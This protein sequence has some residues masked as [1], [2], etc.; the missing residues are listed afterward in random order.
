MSRI[1]FLCSFILSFSLIKA[2][3]SYDSWLFWIVVVCYSTACI[4]ALKKGLKI[5]AKSRTKKEQ[6]KNRRAE[7][8]MIKKIK[9][10]NLNPCDY[11]SRNYEGEN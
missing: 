2:G 8:R 5:A 7:K 3:Y 6:R 1:I 10:K 4:C 9:R 11:I